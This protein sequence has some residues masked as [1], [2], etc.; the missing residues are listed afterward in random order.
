VLP[1][2]AQTQQNGALNQAQTKQFFDVRQL[3]LTEKQ[4]LSAIAAAPTIRESTDNASEDIDKLKPETVA[5][6]DMVA[7]KYGLS[8]YDEYKMIMENVG[9]VLAGT[10]PLTKKYVGREALIKLKISRVRAGKKMSAADRK[11]MLADLNDEFQFALPPV[12]YKE[13]IDLVLKH[14]DALEKNMSGD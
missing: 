9:L 3:H 1:A 7:S 2:R 4:I 5:K 13:N 12:K 14:S 6:L 10:D 8:G 11:E